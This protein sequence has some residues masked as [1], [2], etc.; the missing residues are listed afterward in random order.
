MPPIPYEQS[1]DST[2]D[3]LREGYAFTMARY[4]RHASDVFGARVLLE[5]TIFFRGPSAARA[6]YD[7]ERF[8]RIGAAPKRLQDSLFGR[9]GV[10]GL[11]GPDHRHR[12]QLFLELMTPDRLHAFGDILDR[13]WDIALSAW[14]K[15]DEVV[16]FDELETLLCRVVCE[17]SGIP[18]APFEVDERTRQMVSLIEGSIMVGPRYWRARIE[19]R[20][21]E[22]WAAN[23]IESTRLQGAKGEGALHR[24]AR[25]QDRRGRLL[26]NNVA[27]VELINVLR[28]T[29][30]VARYIVF[31]ALALHE[32]PQYRRRIGGGDDAL[33]EPFVHEVRRFYPF[34]PLV[35]A[36]V[37]QDFEWQGHHFPKGR[38]VLFDLHGTNHHPEIWGDPEVFRPE[39]F[40]DH[41]PG[42]FDLVPQGGGDHRENHRCAGEWLT[43]EVMQRAV[44]HLT[45]SMQYDVPPQDLRVR[46]S[47]IPATPESRLVLKNVRLPPRPL[48]T[49]RFAVAPAAE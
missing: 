17:W 8:T 35:A 32:H 26:E 29:V 37:R 16:L 48:S 12:K 10:Q 49:G 40:R 33:V 44:K 14:Q 9:G 23:L 11:D 46:W 36:R 42:S 28:P 5:P 21:A 18:V 20:H 1:L 31:S 43:T 2:L 47:R 27:A 19:R 24:I 13:E 30:A 45:R 15:K 38:R 22:R 25:H 39:R 4:P 34:F 6:F 7:T 3:L 41:A